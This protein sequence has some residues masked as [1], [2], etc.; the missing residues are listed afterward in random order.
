MKIISALLAFI[1]IASAQ[2]R[3]AVYSEKDFEVMGGKLLQK[4]VRSSTQ[5]LERYGNHYTLLAVRE[6]TGSAELHAHEADIFF[7]VSGEAILLSGGNISNPHSEKPG[8][9]RGTSIQGGDRHPL[10]TGDV[11]HIPARTPHQ[12]LIDNGKTFTYFVVKVTGQ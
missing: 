7:V 11:V 9:V 6:G 8:E 5:D 1:L 2:T 10:R 3:V 4:H 12:L